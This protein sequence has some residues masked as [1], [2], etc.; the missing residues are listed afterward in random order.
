M[1]RV[2]LSLAALVLIVCALAQSDP[3]AADPDVPINITIDRLAND[4]ERLHQAQQQTATVPEVTPVV[5]T[6]PSWTKAVFEVR[7]KGDG[8]VEANGTAV[9]VRGDALHTVKHISDGLSRPRYEVK[10]GGEWRPAVASPVGRKDLSVLTVSGASFTPVPVRVPK[11]GERVTV[12]GLRTKSFSQ[13]MYIGDDNPSA[14]SG[15]VALDP[16]SVTVDNG[17]SGGGIFGDDGSLLG[18]LTGRRVFESSLTT[19]VPI[20]SDP[21][22]TAVAALSGGVAPPSPR[23]AW[24]TVCN[25][26][27]CSRQWVQIR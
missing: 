16:D 7:A 9:A 10:V 19:M 27:T 18:T 3:A 20:V 8:G 22:A 17:D 1:S 13:G 26:G 4:A 5:E 24:Q 11:Y 6:F 21:P 23:W 12:Y 14:G 2:F 15:C 25:G